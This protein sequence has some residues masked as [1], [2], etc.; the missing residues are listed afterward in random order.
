MLAVARI[1]QLSTDSLN[2]LPLKQLCSCQS[3]LILDGL[4]KRISLGKATTSSLNLPHYAAYIP[5][6][7]LGSVKGN[8]AY[9]Q[10]SHRVVGNEK[11]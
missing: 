6:A 9:L 11:T 10:P 2:S 4:K 7:E 3:L 1:K 8:K 5:S